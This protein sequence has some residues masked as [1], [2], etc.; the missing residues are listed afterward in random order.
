[1]TDLPAQRKAAIKES[2]RLKGLWNI[3][4]NYKYVSWFIFCINFSSIA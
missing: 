2:Y 3:L 1:M 4:K